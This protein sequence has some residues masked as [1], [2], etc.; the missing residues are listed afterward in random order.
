MAIPWDSARQRESSSV[1]RHR[2]SSVT[3]HLD[4]LRLASEISQCLKLM[5]WTTP[6]VEKKIT[7]SL[8]SSNSLHQYG[9][10]AAFYAGRGFAASL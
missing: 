5:R 4:Y 1:A 7:S 10:L 9:E 8:L 2:E 6:L 3:A